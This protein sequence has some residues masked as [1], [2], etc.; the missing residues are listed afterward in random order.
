MT[1]FLL[2]ATLTYACGLQQDVILMV[3][4]L[5]RNYT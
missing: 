4:V 3:I 5:P 1:L 2:T